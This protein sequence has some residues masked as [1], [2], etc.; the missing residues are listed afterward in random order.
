MKKRNIL[1]SI[2]CIVLL[3]GTI[4]CTVEPDP[5]I[6]SIEPYSRLTTDVGQ[7]PITRWEDAFTLA[8]GV[9]GST[10]IWECND[11]TMYAEIKYTG[12][13]PID[14]FGNYGF[15]GRLSI[16][17]KEEI[18]NYI[19][20]YECRRM[21]ESYPN[22]SVKSSD[23]ILDFEFDPNN[24]F[25]STLVCD[26]ISYDSCPVDTETNETLFIRKNP[27]ENPSYEDYLELI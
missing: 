7:L 25:I 9:F 2:L 6:E 26:Y 3:F 1:I 5:I 8:I 15:A 19:V 22:G 21:T 24:G 13:I 18:V 11:S 27:D 12:D 4:G 10:N 17:G 20:N 16:D 14:E 23:L